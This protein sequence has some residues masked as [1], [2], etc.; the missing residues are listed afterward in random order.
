MNCDVLLT[1]LVILIRMVR[2]KVGMLHPFFRAVVSLTDQNRWLVEFIPC[3]DASNKPC[4]IEIDGR[5]IWSALKQSVLTNFGDTGWGAV[6]NSLVGVVFF[7]S[8]LP[9]Y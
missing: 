2:Y 1:N 6:G 8:T 3:P 9:I 5:Q 4:I 7:L